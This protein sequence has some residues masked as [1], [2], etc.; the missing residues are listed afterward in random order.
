MSDK[1]YTSSGY[2]QGS[3]EHH[4]GVTVDLEKP[5]T[6]VVQ[7]NHVE[8]LGDEIADGIDLAWEEHLEDCRGQCR[9]C[10]CNHGGCK[11]LPPGQG[12]CDCECE[13]YF[14]QR[15]RDNGVTNAHTY[16][17]GSEMGQGDCHDRCGPE[18]RGTTLIGKWKKGAD[19][20]WEPDE[21]GEYAA[22][23]GEV[24]TQ[25]V[26]SRRVVR[27]RSLCSPCFPGQADVDQDKIVSEGGYLAY[28]L[29]ESMYGE[30]D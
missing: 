8:W 13:C 24:Y 11:H 15:E 25:V 17:P 2:V 1:R 12:D 21:S 29:P 26:W 4:Y 30:R 19:G 9:E 3:I 7:N 27:V 16:D 18:E 20:K 5:T 23:C 28:D 10:H 14:S 6:G 22:I